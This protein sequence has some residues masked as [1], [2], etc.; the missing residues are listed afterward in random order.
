MG[1]RRTFAALATVMIV[2]IIV[3]LPVMLIV[4]LLVQEAVGVYEKFESGRAE[5][6]Q[7]SRAGAGRRTSLGNRPA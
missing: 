2:L 4:A 6:Q 7:V 1:H 3:I 5:F